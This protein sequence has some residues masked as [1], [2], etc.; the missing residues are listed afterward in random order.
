MVRFEREAQV[1]ASLNYRSG[2]CDG[3]TPKNPDGATPVTV[4]GALSV[5]VLRLVG[6]QACQRLFIDPVAFGNQQSKRLRHGRDVV[7]NKQVR[8]QMVVRRSAIR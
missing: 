3:S 8:R 1:L 2:A 7:K 4:N 5:N 6:T